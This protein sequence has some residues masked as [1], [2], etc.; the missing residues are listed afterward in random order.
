MFTK[1]MIMIA[2]CAAVSGCANWPQEKKQD[3]LGNLTRNFQLVDPADGRIYGILEMDPIT[4]GRV[5][6]N[7]GRVIGTIV[8][9]A[10]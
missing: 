3:V 6:D 2:V 4:G 8:P 9:P 7:G 1:S 10:R 5:V